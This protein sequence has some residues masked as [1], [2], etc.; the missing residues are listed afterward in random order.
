M[1]IETPTAERP[2]R[3]TPPITAPLLDGQI[4]LARARKLA[5]EFATRAEHHDQTAQP[6]AAQIQELFQADLLRLTIARRDGGH[7][8]GLLLARQ[9]VQ[10]LAK[11]DPSVALIASMHYSQ[12]AGIARSQRQREPSLAFWPT[13]LAQQLTQQALHA[14]AL[15]N[16][17]QVEPALGSPSH[18]GLPATVARRVGDEW[19]IS[20]HKIYSTGS[21]L[22]S[23]LSVLAVTDEEQ[24]RIGQFLVPKDS[25]GVRLVETWDPLGMRATVSHDFIFEDVAIPVQQVAGLYSAEHGQQRDEYAFAWYLNLVGS[26][27]TGV[28]EAALDWIA[29]FL[30]ERK[31]SALKGASL[32]SLPT[33]QDSVGRIRLLLHT[34]NTLLDAHAQAFDARQPF[35]ELGSTARYVAMEHAAKATALA[36]ELAG[37][38]GIS[39][40]NALE[41]HFRNAQCGQIHAPSAA[42]I[43][44]NAGREWFKVRQ[45]AT[46][47]AAD[48]D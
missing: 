28:A 16:A 13:A 9:I 2:G 36:L 47:L 20:G 18:G 44:G 25:P 12:H 35:A 31:P 10:T 23:W 40:H 29:D 34:S 27:Y 22:L 1:S 3:T 21:H 14:P 7:G 6:P 24:P 37:N 33:V 45:K 5:A 43:R 4:L 39:R 46:A 48:R 15:I 26:I 19:H 38:H 17:V 42:L 11:G 8:S 41:R 32:A 30:L